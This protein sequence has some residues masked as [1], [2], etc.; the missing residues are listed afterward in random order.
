MI[1]SRLGSITALGDAIDSAGITL[2]AT[3]KIFTFFE[4]DA[5]VAVGAPVQLQSDVNN[6]STGNTY[7]IEVIEV[8]TSAAGGGSGCILGG[9]TGVNL[10]NPHG[11]KVNV[12][13][14]NAAGDDADG[15]SVVLTGVAAVDG[16][17]IQV[18]CYG[19]GWCLTEGSTDIDSGDQLIGDS[20]GGRLI[21]VAD[22]ADGSGGQVVA[23]GTNCQN[24][25][26]LI[27]VFFRCM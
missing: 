25:E 6:N 13:N 8:I 27:S 17:L 14:P 15:G 18:Q 10:T 2:K 7:G 16:D 9:Y 5:A 19:T 24:A 1:I 21:V 4:A 26:G 22:L 3:D 23:L 11:T 20:T 12:K